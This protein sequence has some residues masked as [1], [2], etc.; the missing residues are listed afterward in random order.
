MTVDEDEVGEDD[1]VGDDFGV[2]L[3]TEGPDCFVIDGGVFE[4][5]VT[6]DVD[7]GVFC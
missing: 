4:M 3:G 6:V 1:K 2:E 7:D 5:V